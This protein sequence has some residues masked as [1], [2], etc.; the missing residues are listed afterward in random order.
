M[1]SLWELRSYLS[2]MRDLQ[3]VL[4]RFEGDKLAEYGF[5]KGFLLGDRFAELSYR[6]VTSLAMAEMGID[7]MRRGK[8]YAYV[9][10]RAPAFVPEYYGWGVDR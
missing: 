4:V 10:R 2:R 7:P 8:V 9:L 1:Q 6:E 3:T 5:T